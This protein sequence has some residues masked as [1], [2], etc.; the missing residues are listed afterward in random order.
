[1]KSIFIFIGQFGCQVG[2]HI[3][4][5]LSDD[6]HH[7]LNKDRYFPGIFVDGEKKVLKVIQ[8]S[9]KMQQYVHERNYLYSNKS[10]SWVKA[11][12]DEEFMRKVIEKIQIEFKK[13]ENEV[14]SF[15]FIV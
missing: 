8:S 7:L 15:S 4:E 11:F 10:S 5:K 9:G 3:V 13:M 12:K 1:M 6:F 2:S 14:D